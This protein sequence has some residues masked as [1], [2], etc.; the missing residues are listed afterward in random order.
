M[1]IGPCVSRQQ[2]AIVVFIFMWLI[3]VVKTGTIQLSGHS[4]YEARALDQRMDPMIIH[5]KRGTIYDRN[6]EK[7]AASRAS[8]SYGLM[9]RKIENPDK[10][11]QLLAQATGQ[12]F[13]ELRKMC[14]SDKSF[15]W[16]A[17]QPDPS[18]I[19]RLDILTLE[20]LTKQFEF[21]RY[22]PL[23]SVGTQIIGLTDIDCNGIE[24]CELYFN[25]DL[26]GR[27]GRSTLL[28]DGRNRLSPSLDE[29]L[30]E[31]VDGFDIKL[32]VDW[33]IQ[34]IAEEELEVSL[35]DT[36]AEWGG[37][38]VLDAGSG[39]ILAIAN[40]PKI[41]PNHSAIHPK[42][43]EYMRNK[44]VTDMVE[45][46][47]TFK[48]VAFTE[49]LD[50]GIINEDDLINCE[51]GNYR[52]ASHNIND[53][54]K[55]GVVPA[56]DILIQ[57]SNIGTVK[58]ADKI[59]KKK[60]YERARL[61]GFGEVTGIDLPYETPGSLQNPKEWSKL[62]LPTISFGQGVAVSPLQIA[63]AYGAI[64]NGGELLT[65]RIVKEI[66]CDDDRSGRSYDTAKIRRVMKPE[67][68][69]RLTELLVGVVEE[70]S[71]K[72]AA[73]PHV[74]IAGKTGT[75]QKT[76]PGKVGY[77]SGEYISSFVGFVDDREPKIVCL[78]I[79]DNPK[80]S[81]YGSQVAAP[82]FKNILNRMMNMSDN[83]WESMPV[84]KEN[85][86][87]IKTVQIP[88]V[89]G[90]KVSDAVVKLRD[91]G[92]IADVSGDSTLVVNQ[93]PLAGACVNTGSTVT[94]YSDTST[95]IKTGR[96]MVPDLVGKS[97][98]E[99]IQELVRNNLDV[100][101]KGSGIVKKQNP[102]AG[103]FVEHGTI[104]LIACSKIY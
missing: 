91:L 102:S 89:T 55:L 4:G 51:N 78:V 16:L 49:A 50:S 3:L 53:F 13:V 100:K 59:G 26:S 75:A 30:I 33:R 95:T 101:V 40:V 19:K 70:G 62:S 23:G 41:D 96:I 21:N 9:P 73:I 42:K 45:P 34:E 79:I 39:E 10:A 83:P 38:I 97:M 32:N 84:K 77:V 69:R 72:N 22:Y 74:R 12:N 14:T 60:L 66:K 28:R 31:P 6:G 7:L 82:V 63:M 104:C 54:H 37:A 43:P 64:A 61:M 98:R 15:V 2:F 46:G 44:L 76:E 48:I 11:A 20:G 29:P 86:T 68:A 17:R 81:Y 58:I 57:S 5:A 87:V 71:G 35:L 94:L 8:A 67:T 24:G 56:R 18:I 85:E 103:V 36:K 93:F 99:A 88:D 65:P 80:G 1:Y 47:S 27:D 90:S 52:L 25:D 92:L